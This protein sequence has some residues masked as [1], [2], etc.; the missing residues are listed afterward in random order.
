MPRLELGDHLRKR[1]AL[2]LEQ[3]Q[4]V[5][6]K[7]R[8]LA[9]DLRIGLR[10]AGEREL[11]SFLADFLCDPPRAFAQELR[12]VAAR[13][14][15][16]DSLRDDLFEL[17]QEGVLLRGRS[18]WVLA[19]TGGRAQVTGGPRGLGQYQQGVAV[20]IDGDLPQIQEMPRGLPLGPE[21]ALAAAPE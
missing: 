2:D 15:L 7:I 5:V 8:G 17:S 21:A 3:Q 19:P 13:R 14:A 11:Q 1:Q 9:D 20:A 18:G 12:G 4:S 10:D 6:E 16:G